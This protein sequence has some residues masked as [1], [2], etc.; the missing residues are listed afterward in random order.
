VAV[1][2]PANGYLDDRGDAWKCER[3]FGPRDTR[4]VRIEVPANAQLDYSGNEWRCDD[5]FRKEAKRCV[6]QL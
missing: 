2:V 4:C 1:I 6:A 3:G 5:G